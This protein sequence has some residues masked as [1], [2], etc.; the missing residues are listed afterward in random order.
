MRYGIR[1][2]DTVDACIRMM[3]IVYARWRGGTP[4]PP[5]AMRRSG[6]TQHNTD[7]F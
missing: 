7:L 2:N 1:S 5:L 4:G 3:R 6:L